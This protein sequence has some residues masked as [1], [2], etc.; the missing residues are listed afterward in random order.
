MYYFYTKTGS[1]NNQKWKDLGGGAPLD[2]TSSSTVT[3][4]YSQVCNVYYRNVC[5]PLGEELLTGKGGKQ[6][7]C[8]ACHRSVMFIIEVCA[9]PSVMND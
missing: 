3:G 4:L 9:I 2:N 7:N 6:G 8:V 1:K 5:D